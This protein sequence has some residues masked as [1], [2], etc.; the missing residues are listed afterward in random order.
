MLFVRVVALAALF[1]VGATVLAWLLTGNPKYRR[2]AWN[3]TLGG[4]MVIAAILLAFV[5]ERLIG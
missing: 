2:L 1:A 5:V 3:L 4:L